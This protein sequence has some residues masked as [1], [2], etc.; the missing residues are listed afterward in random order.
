MD[1]YYKNFNDQFADAT[2]ETVTEEVIE[3]IAKVATKEVEAQKAENSDDE[4]SSKKPKTFRKNYVNFLD[5]LTNPQPPTEFFVD[6]IM[7][8]SVVT[9]LGAHGGVG[10]TTLSLYLAICIAAGKPF[11]GLKTK[12]AKTLFYSAEDDSDQL[13]RQMERAVRRLSIDPAELNKHLTI[14]DRSHEDSALWIEKSV[15]GVKMGVPHQNY[16]TLKETIEEEKS[17]V[18]IIDNASDIYAADE[19][20]RDQVRGCIRALA[21]LIQ[22]QKG[23]ILLDAHVNKETAKAKEG[24]SVEG[25]SGSTAWHNSV[26]SRLF[27]RESEEF[28][29][30]LILEHQ[31]SNRGKKA[32]PMRLKW[33]DGVID[34]V[35]V[36]NSSAKNRNGET[37]SDLKGRVDQS[38]KKTNGRVVQKVTSM[39]WNQ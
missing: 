39:P 23:A 12:Q 25:Y 7:P 3:V 29:D 32:N 9:L 24:K 27:M 31:K 36:I 26:R 17:V 15:G 18:V 1:N 14:I 2:D 28:E 10:K 21:N 20:K 19:I 5:I 33:H 4:D 13:R 16:Y 22:P 6:Q 30:E 11:L 34:S 38:A 8:E 37:Y 35:D